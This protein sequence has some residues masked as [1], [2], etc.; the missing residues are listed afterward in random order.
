MNIIVKAVQVQGDKLIVSL[1]HSCSES[2]EG[3]RATRILSHLAGNPSYVCD[4]QTIT[5][6]NSGGMKQLNTKSACQHAIDSLADVPIELTFEPVHVGLI[7]IRGPVPNLKLLR[8]FQ[9]MGKQGVAEITFTANLPIIRH[10]V[11]VLTMMPHVSVRVSENEP[12][13]AVVLVHLSGKY[14]DANPWQLIKHIVPVIKE[15]VV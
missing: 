2:A 3:R 6:D 5:L 8:Q 15:A 7:G 10:D 14:A 12:Y 9:G 1:A 13:S 4:G 11:N